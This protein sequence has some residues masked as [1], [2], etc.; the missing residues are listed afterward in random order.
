MDKNSK[1]VT[2]WNCGFEMI[3]GAD[4][5]YE[6]YGLEGEGIVSTHSCSNCKTTAEFYLPLGEDMEDE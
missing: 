3:W 1:S 4:F 6:D 2:C 5:N